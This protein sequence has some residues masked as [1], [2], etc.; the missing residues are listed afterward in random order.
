V[1]VV[2]TAAFGIV[3]YLKLRSEDPARALAARV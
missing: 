2:L 3:S 1:L